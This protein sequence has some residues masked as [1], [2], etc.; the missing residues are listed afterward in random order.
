MVEFGPGECKHHACFH[1]ADSRAFVAADLIYNEAHLYLQE[2]NLEGWLTRLDELD[3]FVTQNGVQT[4]YPGHGPAGGFWLIEATRE[5]LEAFATAVQTGSADSA[6][7]AMMARFP[8]HRV[9]Q[10]LTTF[11][12]PAY[13]PSTAEE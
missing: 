12:L 8:D 1:L 7:A 5:Y 4:I 2:H 9:T 6:G 3:A 11:S 13:F 10:F